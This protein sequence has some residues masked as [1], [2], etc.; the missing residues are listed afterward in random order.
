L[1]TLWV[2]VNVAVFLVAVWYSTLPPIEGM[3]PGFLLAPIWLVLLFPGVIAMV[4]ALALVDATAPPW[5]VD[6]TGTV[7]LF[8]IWAGGIWLNYA[9]WFVWLSRWLSASSRRSGAST[10][11]SG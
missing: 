1:R 3:H 5:V 9:F 2:G 4:L 10:D 7:V 11:G 8:S 6:R